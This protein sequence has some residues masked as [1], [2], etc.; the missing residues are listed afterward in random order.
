MS[1]AV[2]VLPET[3]IPE[4]SIRVT[5]MAEVEPPAGTVSGEATTQLMATSVV[6]ADGKFVMSANVWPM[7]IQ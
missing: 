5:V 4:A 3:G 1:V 6:V 2:T 7:Q